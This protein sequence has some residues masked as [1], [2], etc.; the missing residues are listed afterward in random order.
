[1][2]NK[3]SVY[4]KYTSGPHGLGD[5]DDLSL[6]KVELEVLIPKKMRE[7]AKTEK[8]F[9]EVEDFGECCKNN[10]VLLVVKCREQ[11]STLKDCLTKWYN[12]DGFKEKC[13][14]EYLAERSEYR[15]TGVTLKEKQRLASSM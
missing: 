7:L 10:G 2:S 12:D 14:K 3:K 5:P 4:E 15:K 8:C 9:K 11:N 6:R 1:M 13:K